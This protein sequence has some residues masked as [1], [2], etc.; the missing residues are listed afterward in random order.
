MI[1]NRFGIHEGL[2]T[3]G[4]IPVATRIRDR[5]SAFEL[6]LLFLC[7]GASAV[8]AGFVNLN[9]RLPGHS[10][11]LSMLPM[12]LG[13]ALAPRRFAGCLMSAGA[14]GTAS[15]FGLTGLAHYGSGAIVSLCL[16]GPMMDLALAKVCSGWSLYFG[17][18]AAGIGTNL[19]AF[20]SRAISKLVGLDTASMRPFSLW[21]SQATVTYV[22]CGAAAG[23]IGAFCFFHFRKKGSKS[24]DFESSS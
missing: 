5:I 2:V 16:M 19:M 23:L 4:R 1:D 20:V 11:I 13:F 14:L 21:W 22:L 8:M 18:V 9:L 24:A 10:I 12:I 6:I 15:A 3:A 7:G 17:L